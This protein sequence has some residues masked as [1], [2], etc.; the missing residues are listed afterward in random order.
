MSQENT[1]A[2][3]ALGDTKLFQPIKVGENV[4][5]QRIAYVPTTRRRA[6]K[7]NI[8]TDLQLEYYKARAQAPGTLLITE[9]TF[10]SLEGTGFA[11]VPG[12]FNEKQVAAWKKITDT[13]RAAKSY[14][15]VQLWH[16]GRTADPQELKERGLPFAAPSAEYFS[17]ESEEQAKKA[18]NEL[19]AYTQEEIEDLI[20]RQYPQAAKNAIAAGFDY[21]ELHSAHGYTLD[22]FLN[23]VSNKRT[24]KYGGSVENRARVLLAIIDKLIPIVGASRLALRLS[25]WA[26]FQVSAPDGAEIHT[27]I[28]QQLQERADKGH[29]LA[30]VSLVEP[31]VSGI[32]DVAEKDQQGQSNEFALQVWK[33]N[34]IRAGNY[35][36]DAPEFKTILHDLDNDRTLIGFSR[37]FTS[38]PDLVYKLKNGIPL[39]KYDRSTFYTHDNWG[40]NTWNGHENPNKQYNEEEEK[41]VIGKPLA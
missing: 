36:Y 24:D 35:T 17:K 2:I 30:Y 40:Y 34:F 10:A 19:R 16:L 20:E 39:T 1:T 15:C 21:V 25:P 28:L 3:R 14:S 11:N 13:I 5:N 29:E 33:G 27:Y 7:D 9:A 37:F 8:P 6:T 18:G 38:N 4:I 23:P 41:K 32:I 22:Q 12:I 26:T 31:R